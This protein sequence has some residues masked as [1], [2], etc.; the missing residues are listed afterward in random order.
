MKGTCKKCGGDYSI[1]H[2]ETLQCPFGGVE[3]GAHRPDIWIASIFEPDTE[4]EIDALRS[5]IKKLIERVE[6]IEQMFPS[7]V[8]VE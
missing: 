8:E 4:S 2:Y 3:A 1:H 5:E 7:V 6:R